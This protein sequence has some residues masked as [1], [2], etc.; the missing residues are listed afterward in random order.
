MLAQKS[1][2]NQVTAAENNLNAAIGKRDAATKAI[3]S[4]QD[5][6]NQAIA[7]S[8]ANSQEA[9]SAT[10]ALEAARQ[11]EAKATT[12]AEAAQIRLEKAQ[13]AASNAADKA[14]AASERLT[15]AQNALTQGVAATGNSVASNMHAL[16]SS[17]AN[18][19]KTALAPLGSFVSNMGA[20]IGAAA[21][22]F[23][24]PVTKKF[25]EIKTKA[26]DAFKEV[27]AKASDSFAKVKSKA[28]DAF[29]SVKTKVAGTFDSLPIQT[30]AAM[31]ASTGYLK[32]WGGAAAGYMKN[33]GS[34]AAP[35]LHNI[36][37]TAR[38]AF[39][40]LGNTAKSAAS[41]IGSHIREGAVRAKAALENM[42]SV[43]MAGLA[44]GAVAVGAKLVSVGKEAFNLYATYEQAV[45]G[46]DTLFKGS[47]KTVQKYA[48]E[49]YRTAGVDA[50]TY[51][52]QI[53]SFS[54][55]LIS[56]LGGDTAQAAELGNLAMVD[57]SDN[58]NKMG[59]SIES[60]QQTYQSLARGN[61]AMLDNLK[62]G[63]GGTKTE[64][65]RLIADANKLRA[66]NGETADLSIEKFSDV[67]T[68]IHTVQTE[69]DITGTTAKEAATTI[70]GSIGMAKAAWTNLLTG[71][72]DG[73]ADL[74]ALTQ[75]LVSAIG[76]V[77]R[78]ALPRIKQIVQG[79]V[80]AI[81][82]LFDGLKTLL[83]AP[84][85]SALDTIG[86]LF[87]KFKGV[88][89][90]A[91]GAFAALGAGGLAPLL[92]K[93]PLV[94]ACCP[95]WRARSPRS[96]ARSGSSWPRWVRSS[97]PARN[98]RPRSAASCRTWPARFRTHST[99]WAPRCT[100][101]VLKSGR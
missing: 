21:K 25:G 24:S 15:T 100:R 50:N 67:V 14:A 41:V 46:I 44:A 59:T 31:I 39:G 49:A 82:G 18:L 85:Q 76:D 9:Q 45:G 48:A 2:A 95:N 30:Q 68:A 3:A 79:I 53:T 28:S 84:F 43:S 88:L 75:N 83:P 73:N 55:S 86:G 52:Q 22:N 93:S 40:A 60:I 1:A 71:L 10:M 38:S 72:G 33:L 63:Y 70:E 29:S 77:A 51:M 4:A 87:S 90:P 89:A 19:G 42:A 26:G 11:R 91:M 97:P 66:A 94:A 92:G 96:K 56:S 17:L 8:G 32:Q 69:M 78:N 47:S 5:T 74:S 98:C 54:A 27:G 12:A 81:P 6:L 64:M 35:V 7:T 61:Y 65:E 34:A 80:K 58:A 37:S 36:G 101:S 57:M 23:V 13:L 62:L 99:S 20:K 16:M